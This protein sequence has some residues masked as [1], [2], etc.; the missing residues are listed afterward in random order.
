MIPCRRWCFAVSCSEGRWS[1]DP[2]LKSLTWTG[3]RLFK[4][5]K[6]AFQATFSQNLALSPVPSDALGSQRQ[7]WKPLWNPDL[8]PFSGDTEAPSEDFLDVGRSQQ[9]STASLALK[10]FLS[11]LFKQQKI[12]FIPASQGFQVQK[13]Q[14]TRIK[15]TQDNVYTN[16]LA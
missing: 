11:L 10:T 3:V 6:F 4:R 5:D 2:V 14:H 8:S 12:S 7:F 9:Y 1:A 16:T 13:K 15:H